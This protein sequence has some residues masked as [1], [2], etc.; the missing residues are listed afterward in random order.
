MKSMNELEKANKFLNKK[1]RKGFSGY[2][3]GTIIFYG[4]NN[5]RATKVSVCIIM[6]D[7]AEP[8]IMQKWYSQVEVRSD[9]RTMTEVIAFIKKHEARSVVMSD[10]ILGCPHEEG[11]DY[12]NGECCS[13]CPYWKNRDRLTGELFQ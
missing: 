3:M 12:P 9:E 5:Q 4:P 11:I 8:E 10:G 2:P 7:S 13:Q 6:D 1:L